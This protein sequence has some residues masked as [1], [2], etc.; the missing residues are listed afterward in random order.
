[1]AIDREI[2]DRIGEGAALGNLGVCYDSLG[3]YPRAIEYHQ[4]RLAI[5]REIADRQGE[6]SGTH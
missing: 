4:Q 6:G 5:Y 3:D 1:M 2:G